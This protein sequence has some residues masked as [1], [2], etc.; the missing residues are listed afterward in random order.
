LISPIHKRHGV[1]ITGTDTDVG[2]TIVTATMATAFQAQGVDV[3]VMKPIV[4]GLAVSKAGRSDPEW[5]ALVTGI[6]DSPML[7]SPY[8]FQIAASPLVAAAP[9]GVPIDM[10]RISHAY[11]ALSAQHNC[12]LVEGIG[13]VMV[14]LTNLHFIADLIVR[15]DLP[16]LVVARS[17]LGSINQSL[18]TLD[19]LRNRGATILGMVF[20]TPARPS[21]DADTSE[22]IPTILR[23]SGVRSFGELPYCEGLP[24]TWDQHRDTLV[25]KLDVPGLLDALGLRGLA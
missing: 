20:N 6:G 5:L 3:G 16:A 18:L 10:E 24:A 8:R 17:G 22:T 1:F 9:T 11:Q 19:C 25:S 23:L 14:P 15:M 12:V 2:K 13:G 7:V 21:A 4:T